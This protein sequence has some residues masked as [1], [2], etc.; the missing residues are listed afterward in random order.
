MGPLGVFVAERA[1]PEPE[2]VEVRSTSQVIGA[3]A[4]EA[5]RQGHR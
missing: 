2:R 1:A 3:R 5:K 4:P